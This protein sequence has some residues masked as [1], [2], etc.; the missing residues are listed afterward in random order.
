M[1]K[2]R[3]KKGKA[4][5]LVK[6]KDHDRPEDN[7]WEPVRNIVKYQKLVE[8]FESKILAAQNIKKINTETK[9]EKA[10]EAP[11][12]SVSPK[13]ARQSEKQKEEMA[14]NVSLAASGSNKVSRTVIFAWILQ[15][16]IK[17]E[18][19]SGNKSELENIL[20]K[21][22][23]DAGTVEYLVKWKNVEEASWEPVSNLQP[24]QDSI[25]KFE[26]AKKEGKKSCAVM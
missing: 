15:R 17:V 11:E 23:T 5:Y 19:Y 22:L 9:N 21:Q 12:E 7:T 10:S 1:E 4:E 26:Q 13:P 6:W 3:T 16:F 25:G 2:R 18:E 20:N 14:E 8:E 24:F